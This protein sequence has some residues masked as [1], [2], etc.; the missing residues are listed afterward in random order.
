MVGVK[1]ILEVGSSHSVDSSDIAF[2]LAAREAFKEAYLKSKPAIL[3]P[4][5]K[6]EIEVPTDF[7]GSVVGDLNSRRGIITST[8]PRGEAT[9]ISAEVPLSEMFGYATDLRSMTQGRGTFAMEFG[10]YRQAPRS[11]QEEV[12]AAA[13]KAR[14]EKSGA[15]K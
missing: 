15:K 6:V 4:I 8:E 14:M 2:Q 12:V 13:Q 11:V 3:E 9:A 7:Q 5:M 1:V 10:C